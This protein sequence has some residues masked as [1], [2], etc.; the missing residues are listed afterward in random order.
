MSQDTDDHSDNPYRPRKFKVRDPL[1]DAQLLRDMAIIN[2][3]QCARL[4]PLPPGGLPVQP[5]RK[6]AP[7]PCLPAAASAP[8]PPRTTR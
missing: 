8:I 3:Q 7:W 1:H 2:A 4:G 5:K 6:P